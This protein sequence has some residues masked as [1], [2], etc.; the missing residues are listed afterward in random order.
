M[1]KSLTQWIEEDVRP[2]RSRSLSELGQYHF[3]RDPPRPTYAN[4]SYFFSPADGVIVYQDLVDPG[5]PIVDIK[6]A[7]YSL[8]NAMRDPSFDKRSLVIGIFMTFFDVHVNRIP[9]AGRLSYRALDP[10]DTYNHPMLDVEKAI[11]EEIRVPAERPAFLRYNER[12]VNRIE[13]SELGTAYYVLQIADYDVDSI[14]PFTVKQDE[15]YA[16]GDRFS[17]IRFGSQVDLIVPLMD[18]YELVPLLEPGYHVEAGV[19][20]L[21]KVAWRDAGGEQEKR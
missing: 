10:L 17:Q 7:A 2:L 21:V 16:Q 18:Q 13:S 14:T 4:A 12:T 3:F 8:R 9:Y 15:P 11:L 19:D 1:A 5:A 20:P 6:G